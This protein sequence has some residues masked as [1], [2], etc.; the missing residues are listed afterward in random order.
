M[1]AT[2][3]CPEP[4][5]RCDYGAC[6]LRMARCDGKRDCVDG[7]DEKPELCGNLTTAAAIQPGRVPGRI[8]I[9]IMNT[10]IAANAGST[11]NNIASII[12]QFRELL[13]RQES[14]ISDLRQENLQLR[15][16]VLDSI[17]GTR[18][19]LNRLPAQRP[20]APIIGQNPT[21][22]PLLSE[23]EPLDPAN[24]R[25]P[26]NP[27][28]IPP[29]SA[30]SPPARQ[31]DA[32]SRPIPTTLAPP[33][34]TN[35]PREEGMLINTL[36]DHIHLNCKPLSSLLPRPGDCDAPQLQGGRVSDVFSRRY[37]N[38]FVKNG[39]EII[40]ECLAGTSL[41]GTNSTYCINGELLHELP[42]CTSEYL[43][44]LLESMRLL[45]IAGD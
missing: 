16:G 33:P 5:F 3:F 30:S 4:G 24:S 11:P 37:D 42:L 27:K 15:L 8:P 20:S 35:E 36:N 10:L 21:S 39:E 14:Q 6:I 38:R 17:S 23:I 7:S 1:C 18:G 34:L 40:F 44:V 29:A 43:I 22:G 19:K 25:R 13:F 2:H 45:L 28:P 31:P 32:G 41:I 12:T 9:G 26:A